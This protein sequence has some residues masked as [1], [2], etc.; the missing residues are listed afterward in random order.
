MQFFDDMADREGMTISRAETH[1]NSFKFSQPVKRRRNTECRSTMVGGHDLVCVTATCRNGMCGML[2]AHNSLRLAKH[3]SQNADL[4]WRPL[5]V[6]SGI[7][8]G[9]L[10]L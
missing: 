2:A 6:E 1:H 9:I 5:N 3:L 4:G 10:P 7:L 8:L